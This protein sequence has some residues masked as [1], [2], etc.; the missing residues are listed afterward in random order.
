MVKDLKELRKRNLELSRKEIRESLTRDFIII[1]ISHTLK[2]LDDVIN[3]LLGNLRERYGYYAPR[4]AREGGNEELLKAV[5]NS[6]KEEMGIELSPEDPIKELALEIEGLLRLKDSQERY[7]DKLMDS[8]CPELKKTASSL[9][10]AQLIDLAGSLKHLAELP[11]ST[12]Q[13][14]GAEKA[15]FRHLKTGSR[16]PRFGVIFA[17]PLISNAKETE[18]GKTARKLASRISIAVKKDYFRSNA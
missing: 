13:V 6:V 18:K 11:S 15:L 4:V 5:E 10:G 7:L 8:I 2:E 12:I 14:L 3:R 17:H 9:I 1:Q 16:P